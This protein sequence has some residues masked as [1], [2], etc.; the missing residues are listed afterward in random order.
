MISILDVIFSSGIHSVSRMYFIQ[1][2]LLIKKKK[3]KLFSQNAL[4]LENYFVQNI[5]CFIGNAF[6][7]E[8]VI[9]PDFFFSF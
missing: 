7:P 6:H 3:K 9:N 1:N 5:Y 8:F 4:H 2:K